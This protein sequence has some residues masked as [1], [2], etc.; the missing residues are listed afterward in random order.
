MPQVRPIEP[1]ALPDNI[2][3]AEIGSRP[4]IVSMRPKDLSV[5]GAYQR[6]LSKKSLKLIYDLVR[7]WDWRRYKVP[8]VAKVGHEW[9]VIDGQHTAIAAVTHGGIEEIDVMVVDAD[10]SSDRARA[11]IGHNKDRVPITNTQL[12][13]AAAAS[14]DEDALTALQVCERAGATILRNPSPGRPFRPG[15]LIAVGA[16]IQLIK[17]RTAVKARQVIETLVNAR[18]APISSELIQ[19][20]DTVLNGENFGDVD[21]G[22]IVTTLEK[23]GPVI[24]A[25]STE[26]ALAKKIRRSRALAIV[27]YQHTR[28]RRPS[29][30]DDSRTG[31]DA[32]S[33][34]VVPREPS[35]LGT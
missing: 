31:N 9:H 7:D 25:K 33:N 27:I 2:V 4:K 11:F 19:A 1:I 13:F 23:F 20:I 6:D 3:K 35:R 15:E 29:R 14:G 30:T 12:F 8:V 24:A 34:I 10:R 18:V 5:D 28:K 26:L 21:S 17:R 16:L 22:G 32:R